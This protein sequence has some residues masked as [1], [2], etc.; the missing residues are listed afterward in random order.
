MMLAAALALMALAPPSAAEAP[1]SDALRIDGSAIHVSMSDAEFA[2]G[3]EPIRAWIER[4]ARIVA[5]YYG[6]FPVREL[7]I[8]VEPASGVR[9]GGG[10]TYGQPRPHIRIR[11]GS[12]VSDAA[13]SSDWVL[14]HEMTHLALPEVGPEHAWLSEGLA[15]YVEGVERVQAG[16]RA[17][18]D[19]W[20][21]DMR[22][23]PQ[24]LPQSGDEGLDRTHTWGRTYWG[25]ALFC[26]LADLDIR[27]RTGNRFGLQTAL[28]AIAHDSGGLGNEWPVARIFAAGDAAVGVPVLEELYARMKDRPVDTDLPALWRSLGIEPEGADVRLRADAPLAR[29]REAIMRSLPRST[30]P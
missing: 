18:T 24:G 5:A 30:P 11:V 13:L 29:E 19:V 14:V 20:A 25:G 8:R 2:H 7:W 23:M 22:S 26:L 21:E 16:N 4:S 27:R 10:T 1:T 15:T 3:G 6:A 12:D 9:V 17:E 28:R